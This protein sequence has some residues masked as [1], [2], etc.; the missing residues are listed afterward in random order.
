MEE[1]LE[2]RRRQRGK[3]ARG[4]NGQRGNDDKGGNDNNDCSE[5]DDDAINM[6]SGLASMG[7]T[8]A[9]AASSVRSA[10]T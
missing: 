7:G 4:R 6:C 1:Q 3:R 8:T 10:G 9:S 5:S 2:A